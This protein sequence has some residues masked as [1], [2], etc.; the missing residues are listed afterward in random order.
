MSGPEEALDMPR[1]S[2]VA[3]RALSVTV[4]HNDQREQLFYTRA[5]MRDVTLSVIID[6]RSCAN[7][8]SRKVVEHSGCLRSHT[9]LRLSCSGFRVTAASGLTPKPM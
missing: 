8:I 4:S 1:L 5:V 3:R 7:F 6:S 9:L 2:I